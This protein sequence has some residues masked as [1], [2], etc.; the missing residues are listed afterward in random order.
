MFAIKPML[1]TIGIPAE[2]ADATP[3]LAVLVALVI[4]TFIYERL[5]VTP[6]AAVW[7]TK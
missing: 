4:V 7:R 2:I 3:Y 6:P 5:G 1:P